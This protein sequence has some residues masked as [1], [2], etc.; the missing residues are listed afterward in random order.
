MKLVLRCM[1][2]M[3]TLLTGNNAGAQN[4]LS[5][6]IAFTVLAE[7]ESAIMYIVIEIPKII[8][9]VPHRFSFYFP[10]TV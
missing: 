6:K 3:Q 7:N 8:L 5:T 10:N 4:L 2:E 1:K 9:L